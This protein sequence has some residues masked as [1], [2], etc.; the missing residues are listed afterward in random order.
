MNNS[1]N[2]TCPLSDRQILSSWPLCATTGA[3]LTWWEKPINN[4]HLFSVPCWHCIC[5][6]SFADDC[7]CFWT[8]DSQASGLA[9]HAE[10]SSDKQRPEIEETIGARLHLLPATIPNPFSERLEICLVEIL[11]GIFQ[12]VCIVPFAQQ[13]NDW[14][15]IDSN[16]KSSVSSFLVHV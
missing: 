2:G 16:Q 6:Y 5:F 9:S 7:V 14:I 8:V 12:S 1:A 4:D 10:R 3:K 11:W 13:G 15:R